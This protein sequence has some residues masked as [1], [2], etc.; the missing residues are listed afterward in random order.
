MGII[1][2]IKNKINNKCYVG[3]TIRKLQYRINEHISESIRHRDEYLIHKAIRKYGWAS[4]EVLELENN[5]PIEKLNEKELY[6]TFKFNAL[7]PT[8][9]VLRAGESNS[10]LMS[11]ETRKKISISKLG[12]KNPSKRLDVRQKISIAKK[13]KKMSNETK[14]KIRQSQY[15]KT[16]SEK[17]K[18]K[19]SI[20][21]KQN[22]FGKQ[23]PNAKSILC[24]DLNNNFIKKYD[25]IMD[26]AKELKLY[27]S[28][29]S[30]VL[31][32]KYNRTGNYKFKYNNEVI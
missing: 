11:D 2:L 6:Y 12:D 18:L 26:A 29:I 16:H 23:N 31:N 9:Y 1:Y 10:N 24:F 15:G 27:Q 32:N 13:G 20:I 7:T 14:E 19:M 22:Q 21:R 30:N 3:Q 5:I 25:C 4:F 8:G 17:T 28:N